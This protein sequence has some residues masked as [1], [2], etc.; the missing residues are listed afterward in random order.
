MINPVMKL[1]IRQIPNLA[2]NQG[3]N[4]QAL[5]RPLIPTLL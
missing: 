1:M 3:L 2:R 4:Q 5:Q